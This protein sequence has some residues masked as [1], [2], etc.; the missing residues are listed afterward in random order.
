VR[1]CR[2]RTEFAV[3]GRLL[4]GFCVE[5]VPV[6]EWWRALRATACGWWPGMSLQP[7]GGAGWCNVE[8]KLLLLLLP[9]P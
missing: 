6:K 8:G 4:A 1:L 2:C 5:G 9:V 7:V 3:S